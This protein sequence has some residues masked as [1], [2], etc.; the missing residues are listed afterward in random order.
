[1]LVN[2]KKNILK[3]II[4]SIT[5]TRDFANITHVK[6]GDWISTVDKNEIVGTLFLDWSKAFDLVNY[7]IL[8][9]TLS[10]CDLHNNA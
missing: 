3:P 2:I 1:M 4:N 10:H 9:T 8:L 5:D 7:D 6:L